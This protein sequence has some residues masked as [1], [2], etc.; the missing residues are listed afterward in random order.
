[1]IKHDYGLKEISIIFVIIALLITLGCKKEETPVKELPK[2]KT[3]V[4][5]PEPPK[6]ENKYTKDGRKIPKLK[7][8][9]K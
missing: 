4:V 5:K 8:K 9:Y 2:T 6:D 1:M 3:I 7:D